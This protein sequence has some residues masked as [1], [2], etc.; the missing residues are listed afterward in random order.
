MLVV[1]WILLQS[2]RMVKTNMTDKLNV[3][4]EWRN[5]TFNIRTNLLLKSVL[6]TIM[7]HSPISDHRFVRPR[8]SS[9]AQDSKTISPK[10]FS[11]S[12]VKSPR[13]IVRRDEDLLLPTTATALLGLEISKTTKALAPLTRRKK[14]SSPANLI[15]VVIGRIPMIQEREACGRGCHKLL[16]WRNMGGHHRH[17]SP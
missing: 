16:S 6:F 15:I 14:R 5:I 4:N 8:P 9:L 12:A 10:G 11:N 13:A 2:Q 17:R 7:T 3:T 1:V